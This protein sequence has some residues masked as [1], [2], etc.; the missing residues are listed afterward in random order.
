MLPLAAAIRSATGLP[1]DILG[2]KDR[3]YLRE[4]LAADIVVFDPKTF[5]DNAT[6]E[7]PY[8]SSTGVRWLL[9]NGKLAIADGQPQE[10]LAGIPLRKPGSCSRSRRAI[11]TTKTAV[12][13]NGGLQI[14]SLIT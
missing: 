10:T 2:L 4:D 14:R 12:L 9:V 11:T 6:F 5:I 7:K 3:G 13:S 8:E 1:A